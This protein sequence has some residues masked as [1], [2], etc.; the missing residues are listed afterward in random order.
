M[1]PFITNPTLEFEGKYEKQFNG[2]NLSS[3]IILTNNET[4]KVSVGDR[5]FIML[6][7]CIDYINNTKYFDELALCV[8]GLDCFEIGEA[9]YWYCIEYTE[10]YIKKHGKKFNAQK[11]RPMTKT[12]QT[13]LIDHLPTLYVY[14]KNEFILK[15]QGIKK[16]TLQSFVKN[17]TSELKSDAITLKTGGRSKYRSHNVNISSRSVSEDLKYINISTFNSTGNAVYVPEITYEK[18]KE[19]FESKHW[20]DSFDIKN[21]KENKTKNIENIDEKEFLG[22]DDDLKNEDVILIEQQT[23]LLDL[24]KKYRDNYRKCYNNCQYLFKTESLADKV[25]LLFD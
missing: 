7:V 17:Y 11:C 13:T 18:L 5:R 24:H 3:F 22:I 25:I 21:N 1:K 16:Q 2:E 6:D 12:K 15:K 10:N 23:P 20:I 4:L 8:D 9:F 19:I 14:L